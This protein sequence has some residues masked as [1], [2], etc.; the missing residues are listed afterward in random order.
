MATKVSIV[1]K[2]GKKELSFFKLVISFFSTRKSKARYSTAQHGAT[3]MV[4]SAS[5]GMM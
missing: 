4:W 5:S 3:K 2:L 1:D